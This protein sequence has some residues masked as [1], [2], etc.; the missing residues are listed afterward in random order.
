MS[1][2]WSMGSVRIRK[3]L[4][5]ISGGNYIGAERRAI[6]GV[7]ALSRRSSLATQHRLSATCSHSR[8]VSQ[9]ATQ[10]AKAVSIEW[11]Y[12]RLPA[13]VAGLTLT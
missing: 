8:V 7:A 12:S 5:A 10:T 3:R 11:C 9:A 1:M 2:R 6:G 4:A 13:L